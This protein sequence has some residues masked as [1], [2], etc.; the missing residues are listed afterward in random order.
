MW[1]FIKSIARAYRKWL[2]QEAKSEIRSSQELQWITHNIP[3][4]IPST[5]V[6]LQPSTINWIVNDIIINQRS[7][8]LELGAGTST[9]II[10][11]CLSQ[12]SNDKVDRRLLSIEENAE[13]ASHV[14]KVISSN[15]NQ[16]HASVSH[17][18]RANGPGGFWYDETALNA[19]LA[20]FKPDLL[21]IDGPAIKREKRTADRSRVFHFFRDRMAE[22]YTIFI[23][24]TI[25]KAER[26]LTKDWAEYVGIKPFFYNSY[27]GFI[28]KGDGF[29]SKPN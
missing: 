20:D 17:V 12:I 1:T 28:K 11:Q 22:S 27:L 4:P 7:R 15:G 23:D 6:S 9:Q 25:R 8:I 13:W 5:V 21:I 16:K 18:P 24:D 10:A 26:Q 29:N 3:V 14:S 2:L 19:V